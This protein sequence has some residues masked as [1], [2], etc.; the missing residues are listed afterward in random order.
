MAQNSDNIKVMRPKID[1]A[2][3]VGSADSVLPTTAAAEATGFNSLGWIHEDGITM[4]IDQSSVDLKGFGGEI[5]LTVPE[6]HDLT[7]KLKP[8]ELNEH[9][10]KAM[11]GDANVT[12]QDGVV[13]SI[14][15]NS[16]G[17]SRF[18]LMLDLQGVNGE[19]VRICVP[20]AKVTEIGEIPIKHND[21]M[22]GEWT[23]KTYPDADGNKAYIYI[24]VAA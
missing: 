18:K 19:L 17:T 3:Y 16:K 23:I 15:I 12:A 5:A 9:V 20:S 21:A 8:M 11:Y 10:A 4:T 1:G 22:A 24:A 14:K 13:T 2:A 7:F 6:T